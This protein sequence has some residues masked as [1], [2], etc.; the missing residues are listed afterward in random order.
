MSEL[1]KDGSIVEAF[2]G[3]DK[4]SLET[5]LDSLKGKLVA[6]MPNLEKE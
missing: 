4:K 2:F 5:K 1:S 3:K 6:K